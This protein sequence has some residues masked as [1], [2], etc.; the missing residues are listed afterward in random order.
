VDKASGGVKEVFDYK[1]PGDRYRD[2]QK[3]IFDAAD[4]SGA[5]KTIDLK[6]CSYCVAKA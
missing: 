1:F 2:G 3:E 5:S 4:K 6:N